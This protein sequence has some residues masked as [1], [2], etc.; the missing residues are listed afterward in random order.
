MKHYNMSS[1]VGKTM[2]SVFRTSAH[3]EDGIEFRT[4]T[5][6]LWVVMHAQGCCESVTV[7]DI[8]GDLQDLVGTPIVMAECITKDGNA[9]DAPPPPVSYSPESSTWSF[10]K[11]ATAKG[12]VTV[13][14]FG[15]SNGY[16]GETADLFGPERYEA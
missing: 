14:F 13:R 6:E 3:G 5:G 16:Y 12:Y 8:T 4:E 2:R 9:A 10:C 1:L 11:F 15:T 7:E